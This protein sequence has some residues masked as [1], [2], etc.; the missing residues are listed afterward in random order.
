MSTQRCIYRHHSKMPSLKIPFFHLKRPGRMVCLDGELL[1]RR[2]K[3][4]NARQM[5]MLDAHIEYLLLASHLSM[6]VSN[7]ASV[8][9]HLSKFSK[10][11]TT[12]KA[13]RFY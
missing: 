8:T 12:N 11:G 4:A 1:H 7:E 5:M 6:V 13:I 10:E 3:N 9:I 2:V